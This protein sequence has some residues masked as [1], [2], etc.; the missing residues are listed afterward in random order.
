VVR[1]D[2]QLWSARA[3]TGRVAPGQLV[4][5]LAREGLTLVVSPVE[6]DAR[7]GERLSPDVDH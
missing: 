2:G 6:P 5:V 3:A 7:A 4:R 1:V